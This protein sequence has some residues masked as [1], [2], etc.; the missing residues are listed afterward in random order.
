MTGYGKALC[1]FNNKKIT[2][3]IRSLNSKQ[4]DVNARI[5]SYLKSKELELRNLVASGL[6]RGK[7][8]IS[9]FQ[10]IK[11]VEN[12]AIINSEL[13]KEY[14]QQ[15]NKIAED[16]QINGNESL[17]STIMKMPDVT[18]TQFAEVSGE[19]W[20]IVS[21]KI[22]EAIRELQ[23]FRIQEGKSLHKDIEQNVNRIKAFLPDIQEFEPTRL[24]KIRTKITESFNKM[25]NGEVDQNRFEQE[26][27]FYLEKLDINEERVRLLNHCDYFLETMK[28]NE[29]SGKKLGFIA[30]EMGREINTIGSKANNY[31]IQQ[32]VVQM[33]DELEKVKEQLMNV[34]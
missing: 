26:M 34:L 20:K 21:D 5:P 27:I 6:N 3:E 31:D 28:V 19:E 9:I 30:Q 32:I 11:G 15:L 7:I 22:K 13:V 8:D 17:L 29:P 33:K 23:S 24:E 12:P 25:G 1:E 18:R 10:E 4:T 16:L 14:Y 2:I